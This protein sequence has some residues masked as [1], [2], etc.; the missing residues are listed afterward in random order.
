MKGR[1]GQLNAELCLAG[2]L[3]VDT[4]TLEAVSSAWGRSYPQCK[5]EPVATLKGDGSLCFGRDEAGSA[6]ADWRPKRR[7]QP[8]AASST[9][10]DAAAGG[11]GTGLSLLFE[12]PTRN[13][14]FWVPSVVIIA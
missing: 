12:V 9:R 13:A 2:R 10:P 8:K 14:K 4:G 6:Y 5:K 3:V 1:L 11:T 7:K